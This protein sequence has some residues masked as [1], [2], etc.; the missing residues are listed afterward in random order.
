MRV[1]TEL[2]TG[3]QVA[4][5]IINGVRRPVSMCISVVVV[6]TKTGTIAVSNGIMPYKWMP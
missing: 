6:V 5:S 2:Q 4:L 3:S 1:A